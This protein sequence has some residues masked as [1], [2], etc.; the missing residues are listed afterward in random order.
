MKNSQRPLRLILT[1]VTKCLRF[2]HTVQIETLFVEGR[3][4]I[5]LVDLATNFSAA[6]FL[7]NQTKSEIWKSITSLWSLTYM[8]PPDFLH[9]G[10]RSIF[11]FQE[12]E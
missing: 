12:M 7:K 9:V 3:L 6:R 1:V 2:N 4:G 10:Q 8:G 5:N 11:L